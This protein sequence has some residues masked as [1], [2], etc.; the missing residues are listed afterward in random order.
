MANP[1]RTCIDNAAR[2]TQV[3][4]IFMLHE[5]LFED[6]EVVGAGAQVHTH[7]AAV[8]HTPDTQ[9]AVCREKQSRMHPQSIGRA[10]CSRHQ[11]S[12]F[13]MESATRRL[14]RDFMLPSLSML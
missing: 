8:H 2:P 5:D 1:T 9:Q 7:L 12:E 11:L 3:G 10:E 4:G 6:V 13:Q 14:I